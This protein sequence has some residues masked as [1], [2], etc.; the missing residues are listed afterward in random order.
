MG[1]EGEVE[2]TGEAGVKENEQ[3]W[4]IQQWEKVSPHSLFINVLHVCQTLMFQIIKQM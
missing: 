3:D 1:L 4:E 2:C